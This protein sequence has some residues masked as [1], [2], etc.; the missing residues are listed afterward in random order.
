MQGVAPLDTMAYLAMTPKALMQDQRVELDG[1]WLPQWSVFLENRP[2][3]GQ[4]GFW[5]MTPFEISPQ[6]VVLVQRGWLAR[7]AHD[8]TK[9]APFE[10]PLGLQHIKARVSMGPSQMFELPTPWSGKMPVPAK[11]SSVHE[12][13]RLNLEPKAF[14]LES[15]LPIV[16]SV[17]ELG[18]NDQGL[19][20]DWTVLSVSA[21]RNMGYAFQWFALSLLIVILY[22]WYQII[23]P[24][25]HAKS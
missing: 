1:Q 9:I 3:N 6:A 14:A 12:K 5:V 4:A 23:H 24:L 7:D 2:M 11:D 22:I 21:E 18:S 13:I 19:E 20:R 10:T 25:R 15:G 17:I 16:G 8:R